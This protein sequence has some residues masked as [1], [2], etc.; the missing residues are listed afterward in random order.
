MSRRDRRKQKKKKERQ[1][2]IRRKKHLRQSPPSQQGEGAF[3]EG[4]PDAAEQLPGPAPLL[5]SVFHTERVLQGLHHSL[6]GRGLDSPGRTGPKARAQELA[7]QAMEHPDLAESARLA[8]EALRLD[9]E[10]V[11][12]LATLAAA[13][14]RSPDELIARLEQAV[15]AGERALG[16]E[17]FAANRGH[18]WGILQTRPYMRTRGHLAE[19][20]RQAGRLSE[21]IGHFEAL[22]ELN[23]NDNQGNRDPL[24]G[25]YLAAGNL[26]GARRLL[27]E[28]GQAG[29]AVFVWGRVLE[30]YLSADLAGAAAAL[31]EARGKNRHVEAFLTGGRSV[32]AERPSHYQVGQESEAV[33]AAGFLLPAWRRN[34]DAVAWLKT[35][36]P[37]AAAPAAETGAGQPAEGPLDNFFQGEPAR[38]WLDA[39]LAG[40]DTDPIV[41]ALDPADFVP[42]EL[43]LKASVCCETLAAAE[44]VAAGRG[45]PSRHL[46]AAAAAWLVERDVLFSPGVVALAAGAVRRV[47][48]FS[49]LRQLW[50]TVHLGPE[51]LR[52]VEE[53]IGRLQR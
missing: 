21:A 28:Y 31:A 11:D 43:L 34:P 3:E 4:K 22:L 26:E 19:L 17:F 20:L 35:G 53:L 39:L 44:L 1:D 15:A 5:P 37:P 41:R 48:E 2:Q 24:L 49:E 40:T 6:E 45:R 52:G 51:W 29:L 46:P 9:P 23:P 18:F 38:K 47:G 36:P 32:P 7:Y 33:H 8:H 13:T 25:C 30:R 16:A 27:N 10:C 50:D 42:G 14:A 12:A